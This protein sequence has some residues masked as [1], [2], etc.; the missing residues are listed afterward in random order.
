MCLI[1][2]LS[3]LDKLRHVCD[4]IDYL[5]NLRHLGHFV[6]VIIQEGPVVEVAYHGCIN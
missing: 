3:R 5:D 2:Y 6:S 4:Y 1:G